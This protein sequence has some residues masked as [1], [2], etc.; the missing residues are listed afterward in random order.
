[1]SSARVIREGDP[2][3]L[4]PGEQRVWSFDYSATGKGLAD[5]ITITDSE[6]AV[7]AVK[8]N[9]ETA[10]TTDNASI[11]TGDRS[12]QV[13]LLATTASDGD[14]Y[15]LTNTITT[16]ENPAQIIKRYAEVFITSNPRVS[17]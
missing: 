8:Q 11:L 14:L 7:D 4:R 17:A 15:T 12:V 13:R 9:G 2:I 16:D 6:W 3:I 10:L 5:G 1:M